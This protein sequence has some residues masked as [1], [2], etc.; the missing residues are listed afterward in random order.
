[1]LRYTIRRLLLLI[2]TLF[3]VALLAFGLNE[4]TPGDPVNDKIPPPERSSGKTGLEQ[5]DDY[6]VEYQRIASRLG[7]DIPLFYFSFHSAAYPDTIHRILPLSE[8][9]N[10]KR[11]IAHSGNWSAIEAYYHH[12]RRVYRHCLTLE[13]THSSDQ[14]IEITSQLEQLFEKAEAVSIKR[15][16]DAI[17]TQLSDNSELNDLLSA[18]VAGLEAAQELIWQQARPSAHYIPV[19]QWNGSGNK[20]HQWLAKV[21]KGDLGLSTVS[22]QEVSEKIGNALR[23]TLRLNLSAIFLAYLIAIPLGVYSAVHAGSTFDRRM[24][25]FLFFLFALP[26]LW[27]AT[28]LSQFLTNPEWLD[29]FPS[30]GVGDVPA[31]AS[32]LEATWI[33]TKHFTLPVFC[34]TYSALAFITRQVRTAMQSVLQSDYVRTAKAKGLSNREVIWKHAFPNALFPLITMFGAILPRAIAGSIIIELIFSIPGI[35]LLTINSIY[36]RDWPIVYALLLLTAV[37]TIIGIL[38]ADLLYAWADPRVQL[39]RQNQEAH[40]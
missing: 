4:C 2:P 40:V 17:K 37:L 1:M 35:G 3:V 18:E 26:G 34:L 32:W 39:N 28:L 12:C 33:R 10:L 8:R 31:E 21:L 36:A 22:S 13:E 19:C 23:W 20:F 16:F 38:L 11:L 30:M 9:E 5:Y 24:N 27:V 15:S 14:L 25:I 29:L 7:A 6:R